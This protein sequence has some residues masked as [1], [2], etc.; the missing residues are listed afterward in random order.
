MSEESS[1]S[2][3]HVKADGIRCRAS[4]LAG[5]KYCF[6]HDPAKAPERRSAQRAGG[7]ARSRGIAV[8]PEG[9]PDRPLETAADGMA[10]LREVVNRV[11]NGKLNP[12][13]ATAIGYL[14]NIFL[15]A[16]SQHDFEARVALLEEVGT[17]QRSSP[18]FPCTHD[19]SEQFDFRQKSEEG[20]DE[21][22]GQ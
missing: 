12:K 14:I 22:S 6:F 2:C 7:E 17:D 8:L 5:S 15:R 21:E 16:V 3:R 20:E 1:H 19:G 11:L 9:T 13:T 4:A 18:V 10:L